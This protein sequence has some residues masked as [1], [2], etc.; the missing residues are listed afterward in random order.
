MAPALRKRF[1][2]KNLDTMVQNRKKTDKI[3]TS[4]GVSEMSEHSRTK[5]ANE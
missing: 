1:K 4:E 2:I 3:A 5:Q